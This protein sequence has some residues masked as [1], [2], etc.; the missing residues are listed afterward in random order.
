MTL[1][2]YKPVSKSEQAENEVYPGNA[3]NENDRPTRL[4]ET[5][6]LAVSCGGGELYSARQGMWYLFHRFR[7]LLAV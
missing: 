6:C 3:I 7:Q 5:G 2:M 4:R 1:L